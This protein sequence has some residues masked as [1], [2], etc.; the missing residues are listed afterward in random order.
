MSVKLLDAI[1]LIR[2]SDVTLN[3]GNVYIGPAGNLAFLTL[4][5]VVICPMQMVNVVNM[6]RI[7]PVNAPWKNHICIYGIHIKIRG[8]YL[9]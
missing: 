6:D 2:R 8:D 9:L 1:L 5:L 3:T 7:A 4:P